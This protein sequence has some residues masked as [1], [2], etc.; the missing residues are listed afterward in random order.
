MKKL[1]LVILLLTFCYNS[2]ADH[3]NGAELRYEYTGTPL[4]YRIELTL[5]NTCESSA[6]A[7]PTFTNIH[8]ES[9]SINKFITKNIPLV[10]KDTLNQ[11]CPATTTS[12]TSISSQYIGMTKAVYSDTF[13]LPANATDWDFIFNNSGRSL[14]ILNLQSASSQ[15]FHIDARVNTNQYNNKSAKIF[16]TPPMVIPVNNTVKIPISY[17]DADGDSVAFAVANPKSSTATNIPYYTGFSA[18]NPFGTGGTYTINSDNIL[19]LKSTMQGKF[20]LAMNAKEYRGGKLISTTTRDFVVVCGNF[21]NGLTIPQPITTSNFEITTCPGRP[22]Y[23]NLEFVDSNITDS[24][25]VSINTP[26][27]SGWT[28]NTNIQNNIGIAKAAIEWTTPVT[29]NPA[30]LSEFDI[31]VTVRDNSCQLRGEG[32]YLY[33]VTLI[34][35]GADSVWPGD[36]NK[37]FI[38]DMYDP[39]AIALVYDD[40][41]VTR[42]NVSTTWAP[43]YCNFW[44]GSF[45]NNIDKKH[46]DCNGDG[47][48]DTADLHII[49]SNYNKTRTGTATPYIPVAGAVD[50]RFDHTG[51][52]RDTGDTAIIKVLLGTSAT[53]ATNVYGLASN[54]KVS[55]LNLSSPPVI[56]FPNSWL[57]TPNNTLNFSKD[58]SAS[59]ID[60]AY[61]RTNHQN[62]SGQGIIANVQ[63]VIPPNTPSGTLVTLNFEN[64]MMVNKDGHEFTGLSTM[65]DTFYV[66]H[67][68]SIDEQHNTDKHSIAIYPNPSTGNTNINISATQTDKL[69]ITV[70]SITGKNIWNNTTTVNKGNNTLQL[71]TEQYP[72]GV[73]IVTITAADNNYSKVLRFI[74]R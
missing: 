56:T 22:N 23:L 11:Y 54:I 21:S 1:R 14:N 67:P 74:K 28:F 61:A 50:L 62:A 47:I 16:D 8:V 7:F 55:G 71:S 34:D 30:T 29:A 31:L 45:L 39:L 4:V 53:P 9:K 38:V 35:C 40:T 66:W 37:D 48:V 65:Q 58:V 25:V 57:G 46:A 44:L 13:K 2:R 52:N 60:W 15:S 68:V 51:V 19:T 17:T 64:S 36:A 70:N 3:F 6:I 10:S 32:T 5:Y 24:V 49:D 41:G 43:Q 42:P 26:A 73:Y 12:C 33:K 20:T 59:S 27:L 72:A 69:N 18:T 63:F